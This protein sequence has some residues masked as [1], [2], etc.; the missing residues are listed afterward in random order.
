MAW[1]SG[2][3]GGSTHGKAV[4][5][6]HLL[7]A[8]CLLAML[9]GCRAT[10]AWQPDSEDVPASTRSP[11]VLIDEA[12]KLTPLPVVPSQASV[13]VSRLPPVHDALPAKRNTDP[14][15]RSESGGVSDKP[16]LAIDSLPTNGVGRIGW[17]SPL[18]RP[19]T[20]DFQF[21]VAS[22]YEPL[23]P[24]DISES[25]PTGEALDEEQPSMW[26]TTALAARVWPRWEY[27]PELGGRVVDDY[28]N[29]YSTDNLTL[30]GA[31]FGVGAVVAN[32]SADR[33]L[34]DVLHE[35]I[36]RTPSHEYAEVLHKNSFL[37]DGFYLVPF[38]ATIAVLGNGLG[39]EPLMPVVGNWGERSLRTIIVGAPPLL[40]AQYI[41]GGSRP[42]EQPWASD[43]RPFTD[44]NGVSGHAFMGAVPFISAA[45][46]TDNIWLKAAF[47][48]ASL[49]PG[50]SR[51]TDD[52]HYPSQVFLGWT[53]AYIAATAVDQTDRG[54][55]D[56]HFFPW[57]IGDAV[58]VGAEV[59]R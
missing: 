58:G 50:M 49:V 51:I 17:S 29:F 19:E 10:S 43:W 23:P 14:V 46:M 20:A 37:G 22:T 34:R 40:A 24:G 41:T 28:L 48:T 35:N 6:L 57:I 39:E 33:R 18:E 53:L 2:K 11:D 27:A 38:Y 32:T 25:S 52:A 16:T 26:R 36:V 1:L 15:F 31:A 7:S 13:G 59:S 5:A 45:K 30:L 56:V 3:I 55:H 4:R 42:G 12:P 44:V 8:A 9:T 47:Y 21:R 54:T